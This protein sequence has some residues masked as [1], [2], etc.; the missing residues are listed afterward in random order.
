[1]FVFAVFAA[2]AAGAGNIAVEHFRRAETPVDMKDHVMAVVS[3]SYAASAV[4]R[5]S[6]SWQSSG[7]IPTLL[8]RRRFRSDIATR[9]INTE[10]PAADRGF[11]SLSMKITTSNTLV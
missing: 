10:K 1:L 3:S 4:R 8:R 9:H 5:Q 6:K 11:S 7:F 2:T